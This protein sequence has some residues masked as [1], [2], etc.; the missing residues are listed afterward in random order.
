METNQPWAL[1]HWMM[2]FTR[3]QVI[4]DDSSGDVQSPLLPTGIHNYPQQLALPST[5]WVTTNGAVTLRHP[6]AQ[7]AL[8]GTGT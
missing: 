8:S 4:K 7:E 1:Q 5:S 2:I 3:T 6:K